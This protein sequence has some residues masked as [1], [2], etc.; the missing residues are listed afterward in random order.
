MSTFHS[1]ASGCDPRAKRANARDRRGR[2]SGAPLRRASVPILGLLLA[3]SLGGC[4][5]STASKPTPRPVPTA[6]HDRHTGL[7]IQVSSKR[8]H[9]TYALLYVTMRNTAGTAYVPTSGLEWAATAVVTPGSPGTTEACDSDFSQGN[10]LDYGSLPP[11]SVHSGWI[12]CDYPAGSY[13]FV[14]SWEGS[15]IGNYVVGG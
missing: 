3:V 1:Q 10:G 4:G 5:S 11:R 8:Y 12:R 9:G 15:V 2:S 13:G 7:T 6:W 14:L